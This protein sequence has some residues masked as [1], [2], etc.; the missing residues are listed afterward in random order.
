M[1]R[2]AFL[3]LASPIGPQRLRRRRRGRPEACRR[4]LAAHL[5]ADEPAMAG[6]VAAVVS[7]RCPPRPASLRETTCAI[8]GSAARARR[9]RKPFRSA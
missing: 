4:F 2:I 9:C 3:A 1:I 6:A 5:L 7:T 8:R